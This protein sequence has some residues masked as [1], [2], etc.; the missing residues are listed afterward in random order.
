MS[1]NDVYMVKVIIGGSSFKLNSEYMGSTCIMIAIRWD[2]R[3]DSQK[4]Y[5][6]TA[7]ISENKLRHI[8]GL[9]LQLQKNNLKTR[10]TVREKK[11]KKRLVSA[12]CEYYFTWFHSRSNLELQ[13]F[14]VVYIAIMCVVNFLRNFEHVL[15]FQKKID[16]T[17]P[18]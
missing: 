6:K 4:T 3:T 16:L 12:L 17:D 18:T 11:R 8:Y 1:W 10:F 13:P 5:L 7:K 15:Y 2:R 14:G 9:Y